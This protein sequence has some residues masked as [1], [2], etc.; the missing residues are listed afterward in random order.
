MLKTP[1]VITMESNKNTKARKELTQ[2]LKTSGMLNFQ[3]AKKLNCSMD[4]I[5]R[6]FEKRFRDLSLQQTKLISTSQRRNARRESLSENQN[7]AGFK[8]VRT[9]LSDSA[10]LNGSHCLGKRA[11]ESFVKG[12]GRMTSGGS[13]NSPLKLPCIAPR[14]DKT[15]KLIK[16]E[17]SQCA[18]GVL[19]MLQNF[20]LFKTKT[21]V[22]E[23]PPKPLFKPE[24][25]ST[26]SIRASRLK[27]R[28]GSCQVSYLSFPAAEDAPP[29]RRK[30]RRRSCP[31][32]AWTEHQ[33]AKVTTS[34]V[35]DLGEKR[36][37][38]SGSMDELKKCRYLR[39]PKSMKEDEKESLDTVFIDF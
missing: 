6:E 38:V 18:E 22:L 1:A 32:I 7:S 33:D 5:Q 24:M 11:T 39:C 14:K 21:D 29:T 28:R 2:S 26:S 19:D 34:V 25:I 16:Y 30:N 10:M 13:L 35:G 15:G 36:S 27:A 3:E 9:S 23:P 17:D 8:P 20:E 12:K 31:C 37:A 4:K